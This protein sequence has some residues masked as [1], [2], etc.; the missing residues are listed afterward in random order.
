MS[1]DACPND[2]SRRELLLLGSALAIGLACPPRAVWAAAA[3]TGPGAYRPLLAELCDL[4]IPATDT[5]GA[6]AAGV[7]AFV[8]MAVAHGLKD[9]KAALIESFAA[10][11][12]EF[13]SSKY[14]D[15]PSQRRL[16]LL[17]DI[18]T[19][20]LAK[21]QDAGLPQ[22]LQQ[23]PTL[24]AL[25]VIGYYTSEIGG[26]QELRYNLTPGTFDGDVPYKTGDRGWSSDWTGVKY[27]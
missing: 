12:D 4:V 15:L 1:A 13:A 20:S 22:A 7:P 21:P 19:R 16:A 18:D 25:I 8:E 27:A 11:L 26:S 6:R 17:Q 3:T 9:A 24:K 10:A 23:W 14:L 5:P 2:L